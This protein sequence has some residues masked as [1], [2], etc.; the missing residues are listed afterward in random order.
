MN[1]AILRPSSTD[2]RMFGKRRLFVAVCLAVL[3]SGAPLARA[4]DFK[5]TEVTAHFDAAGGYRVE[6][7]CDLDQLALGLPPGTDANEVVRQLKALSPGEMDKAVSDL[8]DLFRK[9]VRLRFD[10]QPVEPV[11][12]FPKPGQGLTHADEI[13][14]VLGVVARLS[15]T[16]PPDAKKFTFWASRSFSVSHLKI[17]REGREGEY[18]QLL[19][20]AEESRPYP[21]QEEKPSQSRLGIAAQFVMLGF[22]HI[23]P[24]GLDHILFVL[25]LYL[26]STR[27]RALLWQVTA[28]TVAH[29]ITLALAMYGVVRISPSIV[30]PLIALSIVY[31]AVENLFTTKLHPWRP[32]IVF[33]F[34]LLHGLGFAG[35]LM[36]M[37][38][39]RSEFVTGLISF[40]VG[41]ELGQISVIACAFALA[42]WW[43]SRRWYHARVVVP[44]SALI[45]MVAL[46]WTFERTLIS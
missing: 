22:Q 18:T 33:L 16:A 17:T 27:M 1:P 23:V 43:R 39:P 38:L 8:K 44:A 24:E 25:G 7:I 26:L 11:V 45:A 35:V 14:T 29:S 19:G 31:V 4:H 42:G 5:I 40:N 32:A 20:V 37:D 30:E 12:E 10:G 36:E 15:G 3:S 28:F 21:L 13:P 9:R 46:Y 6:M 2:R 41:V 34:G